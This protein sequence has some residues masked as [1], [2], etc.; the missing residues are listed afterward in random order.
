M[1]VQ[2]GQRRQVVARKRLWV[3]TENNEAQAFYDSLEHLYDDNT[4]IRYICGQLEE[5]STGQLHFQGYVQLKRSQRLSWLKDNISE[6]AHFESQRGTNDQARDYC[7]KTETSFAD[8]GFIEFGEFSK[9]R[10]SRTD[11]STFRDLIKEGHNKAEIVESH[12]TLMARFPK[13]YDLVRGLNRP[14]REVELEVRLN[15][16]RTGKGKT[17]YAHDMY[18]DLFEVPLSNG[19]MW[20]DGYDMHA[21]VLLDDFAGKMSR[22]P[23]VN[24][25]KLLD[26]YPIQVPIKGGYTWWMP[27]LIIITSNIHPRDWYEFKDRWEQFRALM[28]RITEVWVYTDDDIV[29]LDDDEMREEWENYLG[30]YVLRD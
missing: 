5:A 19:N 20:F 29:C 6:T 14:V 26:R 17:R 21:V 16:G 10:G 4:N 12:P 27:E 28:R 9:G 3:F 13:F 7:R 23:L 24:T 1:E 15:Y 8:G 18:P 2:A 25:L 30:D 11:V 22:F